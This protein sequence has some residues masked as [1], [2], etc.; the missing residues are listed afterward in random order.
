M[1][2]GRSVYCSGRHSVTRP[3]RDFRRHGT[4]AVNTYGV[5]RMS[6]WVWLAV[7]TALTATARAGEG[8]PPGVFGIR[9]VDE[10]TGRGVPLVELET[11]HHVSYV[12]DS[13]GWV[14]VD[15]P[16]LFGQRVFFHVRSHGYEYPKDRFGYRGVRLPVVRGKRGTIKI[17]RTNIAERLYRITGGGMYDHSVRLG[18]PP[19]VRHPL[20]NAQVFGSDSVI[21]TVFHGKIYWFWGDTNRVSYPL[22]NFHVTG[23]VSD[24]PARG[25]LDPDRGIDLTYFAREDGFARPMARMPGKGPTWINGLVVLTEG[26]RERMFATYV[27]VKAPLTIYERG[28]VEFDAE[29]NQ[30]RKVCAF[31]MERPLFPGGHP[32][33]HEDGG[34]T[35][36]YFSRPF[37][38]VRVRATPAAL[39]DQKQY[40]AYTCLAA[41]SRHDSLRVERRDGKPY[42]RWVRD[43]PPFTPKL[44]AT[45]MRRRL[46]REDE[47]LYQLRD[48]SGKPVLIHSGSVYWNDFRRRWISIGVQSFGTSPLGEVWYS[49]AERLT[50]PWR[51]AVKIVTHDR[52]SFYNPKQDPMFDQAGGRLIYFEGTYASTFSG[53]PKRTPKYD[54]NQI[55]YRLDLADP[56]LRAERAKGESSERK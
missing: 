1:C 56:R 16:E 5:R 36:V 24:L 49:E 31:D 52:Y 7:L 28:L 41:G 17:K 39:A 55:M 53:S 14:A 23:A 19:P 45:L 44:Q 6:R 21:N 43:T 10:A 9:V 33:L 46:L 13:A 38:V 22:G 35:Y 3:G 48:R 18:E 40:E 37:P 27:K 29:R 30:F 12:T 51:H 47:G 42:Y 34:T 11:V 8:A 15:D 26:G 50:G 54:Y 20:L 4:V 2:P 32:F 25:G